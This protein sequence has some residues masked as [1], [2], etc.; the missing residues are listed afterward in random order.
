ME[1]KNVIKVMKKIQKKIGPKMFG[2]QSLKEEQE[3]RKRHKFY[4]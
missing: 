3:K 4:N 2:L 1:K